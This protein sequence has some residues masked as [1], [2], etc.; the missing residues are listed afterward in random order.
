MRRQGLDT[1]MQIRKLVGLRNRVRRQRSNVPRLGN[2]IVGEV[3]R[4]RHAVT[5]CAGVSRLDFSGGGWIGVVAAGLLVVIRPRLCLAGG[6]SEAEDFEAVGAIRARGADTEVVALWDAHRA[7]LE[8]ECAVDFNAEVVPV[9]DDLYGAGAAEVTV[10][11]RRVAE[12]EAVHGEV[13]AEVFGPVIEEGADHAPRIAV[14]VDDDT[15]AFE[16]AD[17]VDAA[18]ADVVEAVG[19]E[20]EVDAAGGLSRAYHK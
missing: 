11:V 17:R 7:R 16:L 5:G 10:R 4:S 9:L 18:G 1:V 19:D 8:G 15:E 2:H 3:G 13:L 20:P 14:L 6:N 12:R